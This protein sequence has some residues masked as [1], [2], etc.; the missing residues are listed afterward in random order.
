MILRRYLP[1]TLLPVNKDEISSKAEEFTFVFQVLFSTI[2]WTGKCN[3]LLKCVQLSAYNYNCLFT[4]DF[5]QSK[6][7]GEEHKTAIP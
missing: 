4:E 2:K 1:S 7:Q 5:L 3:S 6:A